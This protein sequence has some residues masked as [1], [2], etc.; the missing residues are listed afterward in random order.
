MAVEYDNRNNRMTLTCDTCG[1]SQE[2][3]GDFKFCYRE[4]SA[5][6]WKTKNKKNFC[7][8]EC[9]GDE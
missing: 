9:M 8:T 1:I 6:G 5:E 4:S 2:Y 3:D 7:S